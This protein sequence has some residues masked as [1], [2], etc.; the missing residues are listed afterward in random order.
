M[1]VR[2]Y[3]VNASRV[4]L[5]SH[6]DEV[7]VGIDMAVPLGLIVNELVANAF[8]HAFPEAQE[9]V[10]TVGLH[11][12]DPDRLSLTVADDGCGLPPGMDIRMS[13]SLGLQL[14]HNLTHQL[15]GEVTFNGPPGVTVTL[16]L[17]APV[18]A[19]NPTP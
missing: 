14:V 11:R 19:A 1:L 7:A 15:N 8:K 2:S 18:A 3:Q 17:P 13:K 16:T 4:R 5:M 9:G 10:I 6:I 12:L